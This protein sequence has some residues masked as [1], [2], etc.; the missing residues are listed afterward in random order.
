[1]GKAVRSE[2]SDVAGRRIVSCSK[3]RQTN[4]QTPLTVLGIEL[5]AFIRVSKFMLYFVSQILETHKYT[6]HFVLCRIT[7][8]SAC[9]YMFQRN[10]RKP[11]HRRICQP[12]IHLPTQ[13]REHMTISASSNSLYNHIICWNFPMCGI[14]TW[15]KS[16]RFAGIFTWKCTSETWG[17]SS[18]RSNRMTTGLRSVGDVWCLSSRCLLLCAV[19]WTRSNNS[20]KLI[21]A[22]KWA[23]AFSIFDLHEELRQM[24]WLH[25]E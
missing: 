15:T 6:S 21:G 3:Q 24:C 16:A 13:N 5:C 7:V 10:K 18:D 25:R 2:S 9:S 17:V 1:M 12:K 19:R 22:H 11:R 14:S 4:A 8:C 23:L 20:H